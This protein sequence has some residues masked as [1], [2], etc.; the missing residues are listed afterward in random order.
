LRQ[1]S[2]HASASKPQHILEEIQEK[3]VIQQKEFERIWNEIL[4]N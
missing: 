4:E 2:H 3:V 1:E